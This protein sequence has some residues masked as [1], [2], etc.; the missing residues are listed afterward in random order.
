MAFLLF[1]VL[2]DFLSEVDRF[3]E[4]AGDFDLVSSLEIYRIS[5]GYNPLHFEFKTGGWLYLQHCDDHQP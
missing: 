1:E 5:N 4:D 3:E 2:S